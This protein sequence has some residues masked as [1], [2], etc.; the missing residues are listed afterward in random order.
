M[1]AQRARRLPRIFS[2]VKPCFDRLSKSDP[3][4]WA[5]ILLT[6]RRSIASALK[7]FRKSLSE[8]EAALSSANRGKL[9]DFIR[10]ANRR[11]FRSDYR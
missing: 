10:E 1:P 8:C 2:P 5:D 11:S 6:N 3:E 4:L 9:A 7:L